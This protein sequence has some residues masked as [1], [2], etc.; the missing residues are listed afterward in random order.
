MPLITNNPAVDGSAMKK[1]TDSIIISKLLKPGCV[2]FFRGKQEKSAVIGKLVGC[3][4]GSNPGF[5]AGTALNKVLERERGISTVLDTGLS[6]PHARLDDITGFSAA[7]AI[8]PDGLQDPAQPGITVKAMFL[9][10][11][12]DNPQFFKKHL[13]LLSALSALFQPA[14]ISRLVSL[15]GGQQVVDAIISSE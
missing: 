10:L 6:I 4:A 15:E 8:I 1:S 2:L 5:N 3:L 12:P 11:S 14:L 9:F 13:Q 7:L